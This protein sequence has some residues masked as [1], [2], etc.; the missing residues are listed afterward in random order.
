MKKLVF[1]TNNAHKLSE[2]RAI[3]EPAFSIVSLADLNCTEDIAETADTLDG[4]ALL[5]AKYIHDKFGLD[6]FADDTGLEVDALN[7]EPGVY[8]ARYAGDNHDSQ[9]NMRKVLSLLGNNPNRK[10]RFRTVIALIQGGKTMCF[11]GKIEGYITLQPRGDNGFGYDPIFVADDYL[12][13]F[14]Q[15]SADE[16][17]QISHRALAVQKLVDYLQHEQTKQVDLVV[18][19]TI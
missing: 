8:S 19:R 18:S 11:E 14:A 7:G 1:A 16:K 3:L 13:T 4:N 2:V 5:K 9:Q 12:V 15:L 17:N 6:C 10:A